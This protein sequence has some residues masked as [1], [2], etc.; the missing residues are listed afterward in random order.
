MKIDNRVFIPAAGPFV[1]LALIRVMFWVSGA[2][3]SEPEVVAV[4][5]LFLGVSGGIVVM[6]I[7]F[8]GGISIGH[9]TIGKGRND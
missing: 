2:K 1:V 3:W 7:M 8:G 5:A 4:L 9:I 6:A